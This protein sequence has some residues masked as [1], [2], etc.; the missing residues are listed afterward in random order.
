M[1]TWR[2]ADET[3]SAVLPLE[4]LAAIK[5]TDRERDYAVVG[6]LARR[7]SDP[8]ARLLYARS[9]RDLIAM[10]KRHADLVEALR[11]ERPVLDAIPRG[12]DA[13]DEALDRERRTLMRAN[14]ERLARYRRA[15]A[16]WAALWPEVHRE[17]ADL[18]LEEA[19]A[20]VVGRAE[21][22]LPFAVTGEE[23]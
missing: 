4:P 18:P 12:R 17:I 7:M 11:A 23:R 10:A 15:Y 1:D 13:L 8:R 22:V 3:G 20:I 9:S 16:G 2:E 6:E 19:H 14:E 21:G 5:L